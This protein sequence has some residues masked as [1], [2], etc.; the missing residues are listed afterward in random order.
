MDTGEA[1]YHI[2]DRLRWMDGEN[3]GSS[4]NKSYFY[5]QGDMEG[6]GRPRHEWARDIE[7]MRYNEHTD[8]RKI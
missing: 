3:G 4:N 5:Q 7:K 2:L 6:N 1:T 8:E